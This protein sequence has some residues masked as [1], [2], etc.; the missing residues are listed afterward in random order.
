MKQNFKYTVKLPQLTIYCEI[1][2]NPIP[3]LKD[4]QQ[5]LRYEQNPIKLPTFLPKNTT[6]RIQE[7]KTGKLKH[8]DPDHFA[9]I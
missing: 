2:Q 3:K 6:T 9:E 7:S 5:L 8:N 1:L 4:P